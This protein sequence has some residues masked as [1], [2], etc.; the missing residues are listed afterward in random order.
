MKLLRRNFLTT[1]IT[2]LLTS[3]LSN[4][5]QN[6][7]DSTPAS[8]LTKAQR[9]KAPSTR[10][11]LQDWK[12]QI[13]GPREVSDLQG[14]ASKYFYLNSAQQLCFWVD[15]AGTGHTANSEYVRSELRHSA[16]WQVSDRARKR[17]SATISVDSNANPNKVTVLQIHGITDS[18]GNAPPLLRVALNN[19]S[20]Y[21]FIKTDNSDRDTERVVLATNVRTNVFR[22]TIDVDRGRLVIRTNGSKKVDRD[23]SYWQYANY[24]KAGCYPQSHQGAITVKFND[25]A[26][27]A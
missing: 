24:F 20:L 5:K 22:C 25:L 8:D 1:L 6:R 3:F 11:N 23:V 16:N 7:G 10:F 19:R 13:P 2:A 4:C 27:E 15:S 21:A 9:R 18:G 17:L 26:V 14:Y 12:L